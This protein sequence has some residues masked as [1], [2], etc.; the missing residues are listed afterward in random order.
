MY[1]LPPLTSPVCSQYFH[2]APGNPPLQPKPQEW[3][4]VRRFSE[5]TCTFLFLWMQSRSD[6]A[7][8]APKAQQ[9]PQ[10]PWSRISR[11][12]GQSVHFSLKK[13]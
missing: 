5:E 9:E 13:I 10:P 8:T 4:Q 6:M 1:K 11:M 12:L 2:A 7:V 3:Q